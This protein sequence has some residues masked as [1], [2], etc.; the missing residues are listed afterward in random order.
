M[1][2]HTLHLHIAYI[3]EFSGIS[4]VTGPLQLEEYAENEA[5]AVFDKAWD[6]YIKASSKLASTEERSYAELRK[7]VC[8]DLGSPT[9][10]LFNIAMENGP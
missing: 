10:W 7:L 3:A 2:L 9:L 8:C 5:W 4:E 6:Q 1:I